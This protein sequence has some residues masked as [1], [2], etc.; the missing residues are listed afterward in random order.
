MNIWRVTPT[1]VG[2]SAVRV[3]GGGKLR[4]LETT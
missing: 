1:M 2:K 3:R 4:E